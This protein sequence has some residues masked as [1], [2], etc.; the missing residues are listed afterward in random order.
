ML[1]S[2][3][4]RYSVSREAYVLRGVGRQYGPVLRV[5]RRHRRKFQVVEL[6]RR[7]ARVA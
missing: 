7:H 4:L 3:V 5:D 2:P 1:A 6:E